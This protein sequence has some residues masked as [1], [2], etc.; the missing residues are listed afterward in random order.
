M[1]VEAMEQCAYCRRHVPVTWR[2][3]P[4]SSGGSLTARVAVCEDCWTD[5]R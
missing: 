1:V 3:I 5:G 4:D 2:R